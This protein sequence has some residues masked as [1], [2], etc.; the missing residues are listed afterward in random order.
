MSAQYLYIRKEMETLKLCPFSI[1]SNINPDDID[2]TKVRKILKKKYISVQDMQAISC[3]FQTVLTSDLYIDNI[4]VLDN[5][6]KKWISNMKKMAQ[7]SYGEVYMA[8]IIEKDD[9]I[10]IKAPLNTMKYEDSIYEYFIG[11]TKINK[12]RY[13]IP[14][15]VYT[16]GAFQYNDNT[17]TNQTK[18]Y[19]IYEYIKGNSFYD[20]LLT[21]GFEWFLQMFVQILLALEVAQREIGFTHY[22]LHTLNIMIKTES[23][24]YTVLIDNVSYDIDTDG[25]PV[26]IDFG[27]SCVSYK[28]KSLGRWGVEQINVF[29]FC[30]QGVD[31]GRLLFSV[32]MYCNNFEL[33]SQISKLC[34]YIGAD[35]ISLTTS[36][37]NLSPLQVLIMIISNPEY[38]K[39]ASGV[40]SVKE[41]DKYVPI[42]CDTVQNIYS[43][44]FKQDTDINKRILNICVNNPKVYSSYILA[45]IVKNL[46]SN[47]NSDKVNDIVNEIE[48]NKPRMIRNDLETLK[49]YRDIPSISSEILNLCNSLLSQNISTLSTKVYFKP[50]RL[51]EITGDISEFNKTY[52]IFVQILPYMDQ[53]YII[54]W[55]RLENEYTSFLQEFL[56]SRQYRE[57]ISYKDIIN[58]TYRWVKSLKE[59]LLI[60]KQ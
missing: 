37:F 31:F 6:V 28:D 56:N 50:S 33:K 4:P 45:N 57:Y 29:P 34:T 20:M 36:Y 27:R 47:F 17:K 21:H 32:Y 55:Q 39:I 42:H 1:K 14:N 19:T 9:N 10:I 26:I 15:F 54:R 38:A 60:Y 5:N 30:I 8:D 13:Y 49:G 25:Y 43:S 58:R 23:L 11:I 51:E 12:L 53:V 48:K 41:R 18:F 2:K 22:D 24:K 35:A 7:G 16:L 3:L 52:D 59:D 46:S 44:I 40:L